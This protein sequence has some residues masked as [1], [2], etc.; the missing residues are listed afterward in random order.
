MPKGRGFQED[1]DYDKVPKRGD[2]FPNGHYLSEVE[3]HETGALDDGRRTFGIVARIKEVGK[4]T[5]T[6]EGQ[7]VYHT[8]YVGTDEDPDAEL[9]ETWHDRRNSGAGQ[10]VEFLRACGLT[11]GEGKGVPPWVLFDDVDGCEFIDLMTKGVKGK[12]SANPGAPKQNHK[13]YLPSEREPGLIGE[14]G[15]PTRRTR[16]A[17]EPVRGRKAE[18]EPVEEEEEEELPPRRAGRRG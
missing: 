11:K 2:L 5:D 9:A 13:Y 12:Q 4:A 17:A 16:P 3:S 8:F 10:M 6:Y 15:G 1:F 18:P 14:E 7:T